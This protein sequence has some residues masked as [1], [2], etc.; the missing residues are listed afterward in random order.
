[1][2]SCPGGASS[3]SGLGVTVLLVPVRELFELRCGLGVDLRPEPVR[4]GEEPHR[5]EDVFAVVDE[6]GAQRT[7][8]TPRANSATSSGTG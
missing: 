4:F 2:N 6:P 5:G 3:S 7:T 8:T 1:M